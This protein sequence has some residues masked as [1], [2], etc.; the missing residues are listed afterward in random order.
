MTDEERQ[1]LIEED[2]LCSFCGELEDLEVDIP[3]QF[4][5]HESCRSRVQM[6]IKG[7]VKPTRRR[8]K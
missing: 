6:M 5:D 1:E 2:I 7:A 8:R 3:E 4:C